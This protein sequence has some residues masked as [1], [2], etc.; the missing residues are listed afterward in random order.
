MLFVIADA[1]L[2]VSSIAGIS[3]HTITIAKS[4]DKIRL[5]MPCFMF[6]TRDKQPPLTELAVRFECEARLFLELIIFTHPTQ[7]VVY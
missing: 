3:V 5:P 7:C 6:P 2:A 4:M 1:A